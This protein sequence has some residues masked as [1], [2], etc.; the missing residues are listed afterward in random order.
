MLHFV[1]S[2]RSWFVSPSALLL[3][4][5]VGATAPAA[6][7]VVKCIDAAGNVTYQNAPCEKG[8]VVRPIEMP[9]AENRDDTSAWELAAHEGKVVPGMPK[10][11]VL[12]ARGAPAEIR[13]AVPRDA[14]TEIWRYRGA[15]GASWLVGFQGEQVAWM[16][17]EAR[18]PAGSAGAASASAPPG[19]G[20]ASG[21]T[22][23]AAGGSATRGPQNRR[24]VIAGR[25][26]EHVFAE[27]G[28]ADRD[29]PLPANGSAPAGRRYIYEP[30]PGDPSMRTVFSCVDGRVADVERT[31]VR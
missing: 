10:R 23:A 3:A 12:R 22:T 30:A 2:R 1:P 13:P 5:V 31:L 6:Q 11:W 7:P 19:A 9:K 8:Q 14:A 25:Y 4:A 29:E 21:S 15:D 27:I 28:P 26:C 24:F 16:R 17:D 18:S 20:P